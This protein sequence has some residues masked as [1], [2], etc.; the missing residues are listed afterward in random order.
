[1]TK[2]TVLLFAC[3][4]ANSV[5]CHYSIQWTFKFGSLLQIH[6]DPP[7]LEFFTRIV[8]K[9]NLVQSWN[10]PQVQEWALFGLITIATV[11][12]E[13]CLRYNYTTITR[14]KRRNILS[15]LFT[16][17]DHYQESIT[18]K[19]ASHLQEQPIRWRVTTRVCS[20]AHTRVI[21]SWLQYYHKEWL[22]CKLLGQS[23]PHTTCT[24]MISTIQ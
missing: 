15:L 19:G 20:I 14:G 13:T 5:S 23:Q 17:D 1:M 7:P 24:V 4:T 3:Y 2:H 12:V 16:S 22:L 10:K 9:V 6:S 11:V 18:L 21:V 8:T